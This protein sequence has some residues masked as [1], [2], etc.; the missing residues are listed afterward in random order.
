MSWPL[1][2]RQLA[3]GLVF[4]PSP[5]RH[6]L[7]PL[8]GAAWTLLLELLVN[9]VHALF[10]RRLRTSVLALTCGGSLILLIAA[11]LHF[12]SQNEGAL[13]QHS[14]LLAGVPRVLFSYTAGMLLFRLWSRARPPVP[15]VPAWLILTAAAA[16][17]SLPRHNSVPAALWC[18]GLLFPALVYLGACTE[19]GPLLKRIFG[20]LGAASYAIYVVHDPL[21]LLAFRFVPP[22]TY[23]S[24]WAGIVFLLVLIPFALLLDRFWD[25][26][27]RQRLRRRF[28]G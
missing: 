24:G 2:I 6:G 1:Y 14:F 17:L 16:A 28:L 3:L 7:Y 19:P 4:L 22:G 15:R 10:W 20:A 25:A 5:G 11:D 27:L 23:A 13:G 18:T 21:L 12:H 8:N 9:L 26:P